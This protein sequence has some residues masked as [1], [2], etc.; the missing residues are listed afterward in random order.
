MP[1]SAEK[2]RL[3]LIFLWLKE[4]SNAIQLK[5]FHKKALITMEN[6][7]NVS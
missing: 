4:K 5:L 2:V 6:Q 7:S 1:D 3:L